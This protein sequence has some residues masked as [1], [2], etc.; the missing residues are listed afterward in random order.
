MNQLLN[1]KEICKSYLVNSKS[2]KILQGINISVERGRSLALVGESGSGKTTLARIILGL[3]HPDS[4]IIS[5]END[6]KSLGVSAVFQNPW[7]A[8]NP[9]KLVWESIAEP[10][11]ISQN[12]EASSFKEKAEEMASE[13][14]LSKDVLHCYPFELSGGQIQRAVIARALILMPDLVI[15]DEPT[16]ALDISVQAQIINLLIHLQEKY[17]LTYIFISHDLQLVHYLVDTI[18]ILR[19][20]KCLEQGFIENIFSNP[21]NQYTKK[22]LEAGGIVNAP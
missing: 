10:F 21:K 2:I 14:G 5:W 19:N 18:V 20:G 9:R 22:L 6:K 13:V 3:T 8:M 11:V 1:L 12:K 16:S 7:D 4:G 15:L 17:N